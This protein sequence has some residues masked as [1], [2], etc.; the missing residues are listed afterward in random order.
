VAANYCKNCGATISPESKFCENC[1]RSVDVAPAVMQESYKAPQPP[2]PSF[3]SSSRLGASFWL[4]LV[5][6]IFG[7]LIGALLISNLSFGSASLIARSMG[8]IFFSFLAIIGGIRIFEDS[9][10]YN[11]LLMF[12]AGVG[13]LAC[14]Y[15]LGILSAILFFIGGSLILIKKG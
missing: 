7:F 3:T 9:D 10:T 12:I 13:I 2:T 11:A 8:A 5:G 6:A 14:L 15:Q 1:G 4:G